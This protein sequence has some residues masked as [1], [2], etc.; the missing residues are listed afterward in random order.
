[1]IWGLISKHCKKS[2]QVGHKVYRYLLHQKEEVLVEQKLADHLSIEGHTIKT[3][4]KR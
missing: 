1:M 4:G 2:F 3:L